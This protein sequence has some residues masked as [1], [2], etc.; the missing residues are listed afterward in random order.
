MKPMIIAKKIWN[1][2]VDIQNNIGAASTYGHAPLYSY[3]GLLTL[4]AAAQA[5]HYSGDHEWIEQIC[6]Y[7]KK[8]PFEFE[9][10][11]TYFRYNFENYRAGGIGKGWMMMNGYFEDH[12]DVL[13]EFS[14]KTINGP[15]SHDGILCGINDANKVR[16]WIDVVTAVTPFMLYSGLVLD[17]PRYMDYAVDQCF[18]MYDVF[19]DKSNGLLHQGRGFMEDP[20]QVSEDHWSR[21]NGWGII[22]LTEIV[23]HLPKD[24]KDYNEAVER[25]KAHCAALIKYQDCRGLWRHEIPEKLSWEES[26]GTAIILYGIGAGIRLGILD[27]ETYMPV[28]KKGIDGL[29]GNCIN[30]DYSVERCCRGCLCPLFDGKRGHIEGFLAGVYPKKDDAHAF[31]PII[32]AMYEAEMNGIQNID[33]AFNTR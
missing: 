28:F 31:A 3:P 7:L 15:H 2:A 23:K 4:W 17:E 13:R 11:G 10:P 24:H 19:M 30:S 20:E 16:I 18:K 27:K 5:A 9:E 14:E 26:S 29:V 6:S 12:K 32:M 1:H 21:G 8:Y 22:G 33:Q 25:F